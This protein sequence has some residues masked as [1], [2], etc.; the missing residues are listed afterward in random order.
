MANLT[1]RRKTQEYVYDISLDGTFVNA[2]GENICHNTDGFNFKIPNGDIIDKRHYVGKGL[3]REVVKD[4]EYTGFKADVAEFNDLFMR[5]K[6]GLGIDEV[7]FSSLNIRRKNYSDLLLNEKTGELEKKL[8]GN[9]LKSKKM[10]VYIEKFL[11]KAID[12]LLRKKGQAFLEFYYD[13]IEKIYN[14]QIPLRDIASKGKIK[15]TLEEYVAGCETLT[16]AGAKKARQAWYELLLREQPRRHIDI[17]DVIY[18]INTGKK[19]GDSDAKKLTDYYADVNGEKIKVTKEVTRAYDKFKKIGKELIKKI[20]NRENIS[21][22]EKDKYLIVSSEGKYELKYTK[23]EI[24][25][26]EGKN[27]QYLNSPECYEIIKYNNIFSKSTIILNCKLL[28]NDVIE[29]ENDTFCDE[30]TEYNSDK[31]IDMLNKRIT[32]LMVC[33]KPEI[34]DKILITNPTNRQAFTEEESELDSGHPLHP[35]DQDTYEALMTPNR[36]EMEFWTKTNEEP[37]FIKEIGMDW[38]KMKSDF[39]ELL[40]KEKDSKFQAINGKYISAVEHLSNE[41][42]E[43]F[44]ETNTI[45]DSM[46]KYIY[47][48]SDMGDLNFYF[49]EIPDMSPTCYRYVGDINYELMAHNNAKSFND[50]MNL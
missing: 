12:M 33:F 2:L 35:E 45:P 26:K 47:I 4:K 37:P 1:N 20:N 48:N 9:T 16:K 11:D 3:N 13:Y 34:R 6:M 42:I 28:K 7:I 22:E 19:H 14:Y 44:I 38:E 50:E 18:Y 43:K 17:A 36:Q 32:P 24:L 39:F 46:A 30:E 15:K 27:R 5:G 25:T 23:L 41:D 40:E 29:A 10:P 21:K 8:V 49:K 31:Y